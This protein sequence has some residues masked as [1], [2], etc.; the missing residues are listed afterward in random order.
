MLCH[1]ALPSLYGS[2]GLP[3]VPAPHRGG[4][5]LEAA[6]PP[7]SLLLRSRS[8]RATVE[9]FSRRAT[10]TTVVVPPTVAV[11]QP[12]A[13]LLPLLNAHS[14]LATVANAGIG[15]RGRVLSCNIS[16]RV[17]LYRFE[18]ISFS[19]VRFSVSSVHQ[20]SVVL[21]HLPTE[22]QFTDRALETKPIGPLSSSTN[23]TY[24]PTACRQH[25]Y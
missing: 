11:T 5:T 25:R 14:Y 23:G 9:T 21:F 1:T 12:G 2:A 8:H 4:S 3:H 13:L 15:W 16:L 19:G 6:A 18:S 24:R 22:H 7:G 17:A 10:L 20:S